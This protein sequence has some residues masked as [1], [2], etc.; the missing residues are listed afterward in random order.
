[1]DSTGT[2]SGQA[3]RRGRPP[4]LTPEEI[5]AL[6]ALVRKNPLLSLEDTVAIFRRQ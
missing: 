4:K 2:S 5:D 1:M 6:V 3:R